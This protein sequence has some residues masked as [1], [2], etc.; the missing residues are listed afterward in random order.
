M[1]SVLPSSPNWY[2]SNVVEIADSI[3]IY[4][5]RCDVNILHVNSLGAEHP[6][7]T[8]SSN[9]T[10]SIGATNH[11]IGGADS[12]ASAKDNDEKS[13][14][15]NTELVPTKLK[16]NLNVDSGC[17]LI[18]TLVRVHRDRISTVLVKNE[19]NKDTDSIQLNGS[20]HESKETN[21]TAFKSYILFTGAEDGKIRQHRIKWKN[22][23]KDIH[24]KVSDFS[25][26]LLSEHL[27]PKNVSIIILS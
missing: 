16:L 26:T 18:S 9:V 19:E 24:L 5:A 23:S 27:M 12:T 17:C 2:C 20:D 11:Q 14:I 15:S 21:E 10:T 6:A 7:S 25:S 8:S 22:K 1:A 3:L 4:A 13:H